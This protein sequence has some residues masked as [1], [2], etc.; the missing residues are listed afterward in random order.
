MGGGV[1][2]SVHQSLYCCIF[3]L[4]DTTDIYMVE[5]DFMEQKIDKE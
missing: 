1:R 4:N 5:V 3:R 2:S